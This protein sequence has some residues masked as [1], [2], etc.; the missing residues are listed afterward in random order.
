MYNRRQPTAKGYLKSLSGRIA[1]VLRNGNRN[2]HPAPV[3]K[4]TDTVTRYQRPLKLKRLVRIINFCLAAGI[5]AGV[6]GWFSAELLMKS[7]IFLVASVEV[8]GN[9]VVTEHAVLEKA[10]LSRGIKMLDFNIRDAE[11]RICSLPWVAGVD[12]RR[13]WP[14]T[15][16]IDVREH[17]PLALINIPENNGGRLFY[18]DQNGLVFVRVG[19]ADDLDFPVLNGSSL[20]GDLENNRVVEHSMTDKALHFL[21]LAAKGN[22]VLPLQ[23]ISEVRV[24]KEEGLIVYL[25][26]HPFPIYIGQEKIPERYYLLVRLLDQL[27][28]KKKIEEIKEIRMNYAEN[29]IMVA[30]IGNS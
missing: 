7:D 26:D 14:S 19:S 18:L 3:R 10:G 29:K 17:K 1:A 25:A 5:L 4:N 12:I 24:S 11:K 8:T 21:R 20:N 6:I 2:R 23:A 15:V 30:G 27:Y 28:D 13:R 16:A 9:K 22:Q